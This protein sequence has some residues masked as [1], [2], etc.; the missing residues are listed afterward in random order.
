MVVE[1]LAET[2]KG[3]R[4]NSRDTAND[5]WRS[6][7]ELYH[8]WGDPMNQQPHWP[9]YKKGQYKVLRRPPVMARMKMEFIGHV[10]TK[11]RGELELVQ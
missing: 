9:L 7:G 4:G 10:K 6:Q 3:F 8:G 2:V 11:L 5:M 1:N